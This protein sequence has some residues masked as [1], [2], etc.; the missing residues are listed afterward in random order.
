MTISV[1]DIKIF[2]IIDLAN[3]TTKLQGT[4]AKKPIFI[5]GKPSILALE[6]PQRHSFISIS[7]Y[8]KTFIKSR[9]SYFLRNLLVR[10]LFK[11]G[12]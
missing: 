2:F 11:G 12:S 6:C 3:D 10:L 7:N 1:K 9:G 4:Q 8:R 5:F